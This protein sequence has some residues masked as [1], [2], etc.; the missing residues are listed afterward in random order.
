MTPSF[1]TKKDGT[2]SR[3]SICPSC[4][5]TITQ[6]QTGRRKRFCDG[7]CRKAA[8]DSRHSAKPPIPKHPPSEFNFVPVLLGLVSGIVEVYHPEFGRGVLDLVRPSADGRPIVC[9]CLFR[10][11]RYWRELSWESIH[12]LAWHRHLPAHLQWVQPSHRESRKN[13]LMPLFVSD[14]NLDMDADSEKWN[15]DGG[16]SKDAEEAIRQSFDFYDSGDKTRVRRDKGVDIN[17]QRAPGTRKQPRHIA[18][19]I[20]RTIVRYLNEARN[21]CTKP[22]KSQ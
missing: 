10:R 5:K 22:G 15:S 6:P 18:E 8:F 9:R 4:G 7:R 21:S 16:F 14:R 19:Q 11:S 3:E 20:N 17:Y 2:N 13:R 12:V 1:V